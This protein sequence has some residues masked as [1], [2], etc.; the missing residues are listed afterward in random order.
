[1]ICNKLITPDQLVMKQV[2]DGGPG[3]RKVIFFHGVNSS[4]EKAF[5]NKAKGLLWI[6]DLL[7]QEFA[8][9]S[10]SIWVYTYRNDL[11]HFNA[12]PSDYPLPDQAEVLYDEV[13]LRNS[14]AD[15]F[16]L[17]G[18]SYG[19]LL[20]KQFLLLLAEREK[21]G[22]PGILNRLKGVVFYGTPHRGAISWPVQ[23][24]CGLLRCSTHSFQILQEDH[25]DLKC[26]H[27]KFMELKDTWKFSA[28]SFYEDDKLHGMIVVPKWSAVHDPDDYSTSMRTVGRNHKD[29]CKHTSA[30]ESTFVK[31]VSVVK[32]MLEIEA[33]AAETSPRVQPPSGM[34]DDIIEF[35]SS[36]VPSD[37]SGNSSPRTLSAK[38]LVRRSA[39]ST[40]LVSYHSSSELSKFT[41]EYLHPTDPGV[42]VDKCASPAPIRQTM[43][44]SDEKTPGPIYSPDTRTSST[45]ASLSTLRLHRKKSGSAF[46]RTSHLARRLGPDFKRVD[47][48]D[49]TTAGEM[50]AFDDDEDDEEEE[51]KCSGQTELDDEC[52][53]GLSD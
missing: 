49:R 14:A 45:A 35:S 22:A 11:F 25:P 1:M 36:P 34:I 40:V 7:P 29:M 3:S 9:V 4:G 37:E 15:S 48:K 33:E 38:F 10:V 23:R 24:L 32:S 47:S 19:G 52:V 5:R 50:T 51:S 8:D 41:V 17:V 26:L 21:E 46:S 42:L 18:H 39:N 31:F 12:N 53:L 6:K 20:I 30:D 28:F 27:T 43:P 44:S 2:H 13:V 16:V